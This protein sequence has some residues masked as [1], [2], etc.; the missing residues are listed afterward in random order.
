MSII[1]QEDDLKGLPDDFLAR[2]LENPSGQY[3]QFLVFTELNRRADMRERFA[4]QQAQ[5]PTNTMAEEMLAKFSG[6]GQAMPPEMMP[7]DMG[8]SGMMPP[9]M[10][11]PQ[12]M[13]PQ[14]MAMQGMPPEMGPP[15]DMPMQGMPTQMMRD[16]GVVRGFK[17]GDVI[18]LGPEI[19]GTQRGGGFFGLSRI[20]KPGSPEEKEVFRR[21]NELEKARDAG[22]RSPELIEEMQRLSALIEPGTKPR[23]DEGFRSASARA[24]NLGPTLGKMLDASEKS[25][26]AEMS[27]KDALKRD[28]G[29]SVKEDKPVVRDVVVPLTSRVKRLDTREGSEVAAASESLLPVV[30]GERGS[31]SFQT[32]YDEVKGSIGKY[33][34]P[35]FETDLTSLNEIIDASPPDV[36]YTTQLDD[37]NKM[38]NEIKPTKPDYSDLDKFEAMLEEL[39]PA[40][41]SDVTRGRALMALGQGLLG[42]P[43]FAEGL[44]AGAG[45]IGKVYGDDAAA[46]REYNKTRIASRQA[47]MQSRDQR[48]RFGAA[49]EAEQNRSKIAARN[50]QMQAA[51]ERERFRAG[52][53]Q[54]HN[55]H[56]VATR[57]ALANTKDAREIAKA[58]SDF[59]S[60]R[61]I[62]DVTSQLYSA[63]ARSHQARLREQSDA[64]QSQITALEAQL[65]YGPETD[66]TNRINSQIA[67][68]RKQ[69]IA[70]IGSPRVFNLFAPGTP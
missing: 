39:N 59:Q 45:G 49:A 28:L 51:D 44:S 15:M 42:A 3:P 30:T 56:Q 33:T 19:Y 67:Q 6:V 55:E 63:D 16:G 36:K 20:V 17:D 48:A 5:A 47:L 7:P 69:Q 18:N 1:R 37:F 10:G 70:L 31:P 66:E 52:Q 22:L 9:G 65:G 53:I 40:P 62:G 23:P 26:Q 50:A 58:N 27:R 60:R 68:L 13:P 32:R 12:G 8:A 14:E 29:V 61:A 38:L 11:A 43:T 34:P 21:L 4:E 2:E 46:Q 64:I 41:N 35:V 25:G 54:K 57:I 24:V